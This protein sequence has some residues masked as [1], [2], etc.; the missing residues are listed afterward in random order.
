VDNLSSLIKRYDNGVRL[1]PS[2]LKVREGGEII[3]DI[4]F[5]NIIPHFITINEYFLASY[6]VILA[7]KAHII[8]T[9]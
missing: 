7:M 8:T 2:S 3:Y 4:E 6:S 9:R 5:T 1:L